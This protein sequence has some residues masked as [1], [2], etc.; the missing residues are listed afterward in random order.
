MANYYESSNITVFP[1]SNAVDNGKV[2]S[3]QNIRDI[4]TRLRVNNYKL[5]P[6]QFNLT[7]T[8]DNVSIS[9]GVAN[10]NGY[11]IE[12][13]TVTT[14]DHPTG[15]GNYKVVL[16]VVLAN[17][18]IKGDVTSGTTTVCE[19]VAIRFVEESA[20]ITENDLVLGDAVYTSGSLTSVTTNTTNLYPFASNE[21][22]IDEY[23]EVT[24]PPNSL[25]DWLR[26]IIPHT[27][28]SKIEDDIKVGSLL[29]RDDQD[30]NVFDLN[31]SDKNIKVF[32]SETEYSSMTSTGLSFTNG[33]SSTFI[34]SNGSK[35]GVSIGSYEHLDIDVTD[36]IELRGNKTPISIFTTDN[37]ISLYNSSIRL[38]LDDINDKLSVLL[39][40]E[41]YMK[42]APAEITL[43]NLILTPSSNVLTTRNVADITVTPKVIGTK[44]ALSHSI[45]IGTTATLN[46]SGLFTD[47]SIVGENILT[48]GYVASTNNLD[49]TTGSTY[50]RLNKNS[51]SINS[52]PGNDGSII[53]SVNGSTKSTIRYTNTLNQLDIVTDSMVVSGTLSATKVYN[54]VYNGVGE[55]FRKNRDEVIEYGDVVCIG[56]DGLVHKVR[57]RYDVDRIV[58]ICSDTIGFEL[59]GQDIPKDEQVEV[60]LV[61]QIWVKTKSEE[62]FPGEWVTANDDGTV[63]VCTKNNNDRFA[64]A[65][66]GVVDGKV[67][68]L[69]SGR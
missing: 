4:I 20:E 6:S 22:I 41:E 42:I 29:F 47:D 49:M 55:I 31:V 63:S 21:I 19:G 57:N 40:Q 5:G 66:T 14:S 16:S 51:I 36:G 28:V 43:G 56:R 53:F 24:T 12:A 1:S 17:G 52:V 25:T 34:E 18:H 48:D 68:V 38:N 8:G 61:G 64:L 59:G 7:R 10:I 45:T 39:G 60:E 50:S 13:S 2:T 58:G 3:E 62:I 30:S 54:A 23:D 44:I 26:N 11:R 35:L 32:S 69:Y 65:L 37:N 46:S 27:Y 15:S 67:R 9:S 33:D